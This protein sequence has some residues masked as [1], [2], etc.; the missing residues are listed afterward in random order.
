MPASTKGLG[1]RNVASAVYIS[2]DMCASIGSLSRTSA[3]KHVTAKEVQR[4]GLLGLP[5]A[6]LAW[7]SQGAHPQTQSKVAES[8]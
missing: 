1:C 2:A 4:H 6:S 5:K 7:L 3:R 8:Q